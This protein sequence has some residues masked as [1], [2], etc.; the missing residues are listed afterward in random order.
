MSGHNKWSQI[1][2]KKGAADAKKSK[3]FGLLAKSIT[4]EA[5]KSGGDK[6]APGLRRAIEKARVANMP[7]DNVERAIKNA[8]GAGGN[9][10]EIIYEAYGP[11]G[12]ALVIEALTD[13]KNRT[14]QE[15]KH[16]LDK[17]G[18]NLAAPGAA[19]WAFQKTEAGWQAKAPTAIAA[20]EKTQLD[21]LLVELEEHD[22]VKNIFTNAA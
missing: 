2:H 14:A 18:A 6:N 11:G 8:A 4:I 13:N 16:L 9:L 12:S 7:N 17:N 1:K 3:L 15:I 5:E 20:T 22:D 21:N 19:L 10:E